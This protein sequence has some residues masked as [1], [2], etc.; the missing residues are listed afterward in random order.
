M[1]QTKKFNFTNGIMDEEQIEN[2]VEAY[3]SRLMT[4][5]NGFFAQIDAAEAVS[6]ISIIPFEK[7]LREELEGESLEVVEIAVA[8]LKKLAAEELEIMKGYLEKL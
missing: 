8:K 6:R 2:W 4:L 7:L 1:Y 3:F 5:F